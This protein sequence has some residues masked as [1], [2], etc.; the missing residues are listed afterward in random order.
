MVSAW[1][2]NGFLTND[3][4][5]VRRIVFSFVVRVWS[6]KAVVLSFV[7]LFILDLVLVV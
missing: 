3:F 4:F 6:L 1:V 5:F 7:L 2:Q